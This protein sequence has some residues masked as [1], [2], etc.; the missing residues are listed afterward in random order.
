MFQLSHCLYSW[1]I[2]CLRLSALIPGGSPPAPKGRFVVLI[3]VKSWVNP[4]GHGRLEGIGQ[5]RNQR[6]HWESNP[7]TWQLVAWCLIQL[8]CVRPCASQQTNTRYISSHNHSLFADMHSK[9]Y[10]W[11]VFMTTGGPLMKPV[12]VYN[13]FK[14]S[15]KSLPAMFIAN[16]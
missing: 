6:P 16:W 10:N 14:L 4:Q 5:L 13:I 7:G 12:I 1:L 15:V 8:C 9:S 3:T 11:T 2:D